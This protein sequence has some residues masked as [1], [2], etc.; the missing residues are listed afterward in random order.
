[1]DEN[2]PFLDD[3][4]S[5]YNDVTSSEY[6]RDGIYA[7][8]TNYNAMEQRMFVEN[9]YS[10]LF[11]TRRGG[12]NLSSVWMNG[13]MKLN[14]NENVDNQNTW[15]GLYRIVSRAN[16]V[17]E[18]SVVDEGS[19]DPSQLRIN[20][21]AGHAYFSRA[22]SYFSLTRL[23]GDIP[24]WTSLATYDDIHRA[25]TP[26]KE[27][28]NLIIEDAK[29][30]KSLLN[31]SAGVGFPKSHAAQ[32]LLTKVYMLLAT[33]PELQDASLSEM[34]YWNLAYTEA[35]DIYISGDYSLEAEYASLFDGTNENSEESIFELQNSQDATNSQMG[36]NYTP[37]KYKAGQAFGWFYVSADVYDYHVAHY[38]SDPRL[39]ATYLH[40]YTRADTGGTVRVYPSNSTRGSFGNAH[41]YLFKHAEKDKSHTNQFNSQN[42]IIYRYADLLLMLAEISNELE[43]GE[44]LGYVTE[45][46]KR[47]GQIPHAGYLADKNSFRDAIMDEYRFELLG[48]GLDSYNNRRRGYAYF[49]ENTINRH[50]NN[51]NF[52]AS[53]D[54]L[55]NDVES[56]VMLLEIPLLEINNNELLND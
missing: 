20:D 22:F 38:P 53:V 16:A 41:P 4:V 40:E 8:F 55:L 45:V 50:N 56:E 2:P 25:K 11:T 21:V 28:Y 18:N 29:Q 9:G 7:A 36:R 1:M 27:V 33:N 13:V 35:K 12:N 10:G 49:L 14:P 39:D 6:A 34:D 32:M 47:S 42:L 31:G 54:V 51:P 24:I 17:I 43:N 3:P 52:K 37:W 19:S 26:T 30:A 15:I 44:E 46:L 23:W 48:E 5:L